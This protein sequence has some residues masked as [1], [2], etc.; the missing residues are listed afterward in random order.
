M[1]DLRRT[2]ERYPGTPC[3]EALLT[4]ANGPRSVPLERRPGGTIGRARVRHGRRPA[5]DDVLTARGLAP[6]HRRRPVA[7]Y[8][9]N[10]DPAVL[11]RKFATAGV[12]VVAPL[13]PGRVANARLAVSA[14]VS[15][16]GY[17]PAGVARAPGRSLPVVVAWLDDAQARC[18]DATEPNYRPTVPDGDEHPVLLHRDDRPLP[19]VA[20]Y[21]PR[22]GV[23]AVEPPP[24]GQLDVWR[25]VLAAVPSLVGLLGTG[26]DADDARLLA[27]LRRLAVDPQL[28]DAACAVLA[29][30]ARPPGVWS[31]PP[32]G[33]GG[34]D[35]ELRLP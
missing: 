20:L 4:G 12:S 30:C 25:A 6:V 24:S 21:S 33:P 17:L 18:L 27:L 31:A 14:H 23:L 9:S 32:G 26:A 11:Q 29:R 16:P 28:R 8:G 19:G 3:T 35:G 1:T 2:P 15:V 10:A 34:P 22:H 7:A 5:L 13:W